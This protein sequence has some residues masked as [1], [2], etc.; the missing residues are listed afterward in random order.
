MHTRS[1]SSGQW[2]GM[3]KKQR[4]T[5]LKIAKSN[6]WLDYWP[7]EFESNT[8]T[9]FIFASMNRYSYILMKKKKTVW[10]ATRNSARWQM[11]KWFYFNWQ[12]RSIF[13]LSYFISNQFGILRSHSYRNG[14]TYRLIKNEIMEEI[15]LPFEDFPT[16]LSSIASII[17]L[18]RSNHNHS[19]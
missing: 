16:S 11:F 9:Y 1:P 8:G 5:A 19:I 18:F 6:K 15:V 12:F 17:R 13:S 14:R 10:R 7:F 4:R 2:N 3:E